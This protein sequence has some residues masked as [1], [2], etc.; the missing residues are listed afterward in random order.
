MRR[1][2]IVICRVIGYDFLGTIKVTLYIVIIVCSCVYS[3]FFD[4][5]GKYPLNEA[6][7]GGNKSLI[8]LLEDAKS[9][10]LQDF[11]PTLNKSRPCDACGSSTGENT[12]RA[13]IERPVKFLPVG[14]FSL[15]RTNWF[16]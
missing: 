2:Q 15:Q 14:L 16:I 5:G 12:S 1:L 13:T 10:Q 9:N 6:R 3:A 4:F 11:L 8:E 7:V